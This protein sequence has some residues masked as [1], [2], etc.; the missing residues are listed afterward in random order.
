MKLMPLNRQQLIL[1]GSIYAALMLLG[2]AVVYYFWPFGDFLSQTILDSITTISALV[3]TIILLIL[4]RYY[5][6]GEPPRQIW[7]YFTVALALWTLGEVIWAIY[8]LVFGEV[9][10]LSAADA[11]WALG[12]VFFTAA[13]ASQ[14][15]LLSFDK[16]RKPIW[17]AL[18]LWIIALA[19]TSLVLIFVESKEPAHSSATGFLAFLETE[20][21]VSEFLLYFYPF[22]DLA[23][24]IASLVLIIKFRG[25]SLAR[26]WLSLFAFVFSDTFYTWAIVSGLYDWSNSPNNPIRLVVDMV[27]IAAY[28]FMSWGLLQ[29]YLVLRFGAATKTNTSPLNRVNP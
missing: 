9:P 28:L 2:Y 17:V 16:S 12:Y 24:A 25:A 10:S 4:L 23:I 29:H 3:C 15:R 22:G 5:Q 27:Y 26:P 21:F 14:Y 13:I 11:F 7:I 8:N 6:R 20:A 1:T 18:G 19:L